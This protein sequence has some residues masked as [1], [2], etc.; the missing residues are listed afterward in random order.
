MTKPAFS[1]WTIIAFFTGTLIGS[2]SIWQWKQSQVE[3][4]KAEL[5]RLVR[6]TELRRQQ[7]ELYAKF[8]EISR[9]YVESAT[10]YSKS[11]QPETNNKIRSEERRVGKECRL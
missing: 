1:K 5:E 10:L 4:Q 3:A 6:T 11:P 2:G 7:N 8:I 9:K